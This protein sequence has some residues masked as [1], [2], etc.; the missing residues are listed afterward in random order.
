[1]WSLL[2]VQPPI[3]MLLCD[4]HPP[5]PPRLMVLCSHLLAN[6]QPLKPAVWVL[7]DTHQPE[8]QARS[9]RCAGTTHGSPKPL[10]CLRLEHGTH[11]VTGSCWRHL[12][13]GHACMHRLL[14]AAV[15]IHQN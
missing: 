4:H 15:Y 8:A 1:V 9:F 3:A 13:T 11:C 12:P 5:P 2:P 10:C 14:V 6:P 7:Q